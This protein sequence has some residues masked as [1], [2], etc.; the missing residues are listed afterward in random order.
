MKNA[1]EKKPHLVTVALTRS[2]A[3]R[4]AHAACSREVGVSD[5]LRSLVE[6]LPM[7]TD[8]VPDEGLPYAPP[9]HRRGTAK[10]RVVEVAGKTVRLTHATA[11]AYA[12]LLARS[13]DVVAPEDLGKYP[14]GIIRR[15]VRAVEKAGAP[16]W[17]HRVPGGGWRLVPPDHHAYDEAVE[18]SRSVVGRRRTRRKKARRPLLTKEERSKIQRDAW[19]RRKLKWHPKEEVRTRVKKPPLTK[20]ERSRI[21]RDAWARRTPEERA[22]IMR[23]VGAKRTPESRSEAFRAKVTPERRAEIARLGGLAKVRAR[24]TEDAR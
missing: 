3:R 11:R 9:P 19:V 13:P 4:L 22:R 18:A 15:L 16:A 21:Q 7:P 2:Q 10:R 24:A 23:A 12:V 8:D 5:V 1:E 6:T 20:E 14:A 17:V